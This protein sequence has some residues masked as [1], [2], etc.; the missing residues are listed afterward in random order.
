MFGT[1]FDF[2]VE[3]PGFEQVSQAVRDSFRELMAGRYNQSELSEAMGSAANR[4]SRFVGGKRSL[5]VDESL[6]LLGLLRTDPALFLQLVRSHLPM[7]TPASAIRQLCLPPNSAPEPFLL[8]ISARL[9]SPR[10]FSAEATSR[11]AEI[12]ELDH[13]R[14][15][16]ALA[17][18]DQLERVCLELAQEVASGTESDR[19]HRE[20]VRGLG[21]WATISRTLGE[22]EAAGQAYVLGFELVHADDREGLALLR[23]RAAYLLIDCGYPHFALEF[24]SQATEHFLLARQ[25]LEFAMCLVDRGIILMKTRQEAAAG[26]LFEDALELL[27]ADARLYRI[28]AHHWLSLRAERARDIPEARRRLNLA[29]REFGDARD[30]LLGQLCW[31]AGR[32]AG[33][34]GAFKEAHAQLRQALQ[35]LTEMGQ[36][37]EGELVLI[38][39][40]QFQLQQC[41][42]EDLRE[43]GREILARLPKNRHSRRASSAL[44]KLGNCLL[45]RSPSLSDL[46]EAR[47]ALE[48]AGADLPPPALKYS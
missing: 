15:A 7:P 22:K 9:S 42:L 38:D 10:P 17:A 44:I 46:D 13:L 12:D 6:R 19:A 32:H 21:L 24:L 33:Q 47:R 5:T 3:D 40:A 31:S 23:K 11:Q 1:D 27:P 35:L 4:I 16:G 39:I 26:Q 28:A 20:L 36:S 45:W 2:E 48:E 14:F 18:R 37:F 29:I 25:E 41:R 8:E 43:T 30:S 34:S